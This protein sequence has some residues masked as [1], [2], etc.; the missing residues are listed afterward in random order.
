MQNEE[1]LH[2]AKNSKSPMFF[3]FICSS[4]MIGFA[5][6]ILLFKLKYSSQPIISLS[7]TLDWVLMGIVI[8]GICMIIA[9]FYSYFTNFLGITKSGI[10]MKYGVMHQKIPFADIE[11][12]KKYVAGKYSQGFTG[13]AYTVIKLKNGAET[14]ASSIANIE[15][16]TN[17]IKLYYPQFNNDKG[18]IESYN[19]AINYSLLITVIILGFAIYWTYKILVNMDIHSSGV[20]IL[21]SGVVMLYVC[22]IY[23]LIKL[24]KQI[25]NRYFSEETR[26]MLNSIKTSEKALKNEQDIKEEDRLK[27]IK[28]QEEE[29]ILTNYCPICGAKLINFKCDRCKVSLDNIYDVKKFYCMNCGTKRKDLELECLSCKLRF[30]L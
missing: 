8:T 15:D 29:S 27:K 4:L 10:V 9:S 22:G 24:V 18:I 26:A 23:Q 6:F 3:T 17:K 12:I 13:K 30:N 7:S 28:E 21:L 14:L 2:K 25:K 1:I 16:F 19:D 11:L 5:V 20:Q